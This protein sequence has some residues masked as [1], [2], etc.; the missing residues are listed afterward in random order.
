M[1]ARRHG[2]CDLDRVVTLDNILDGDDGVGT[3]GHDTTSGDRHRL[4][5]AEVARRGLAGGD[6]A[7]HR[8]RAG[9]VDATN[10]VPVHRGAPERRQ[11]DDC[12][13]GL[14]RDARERL[15]HGHVLGR[16]GMRAGEHER[17]RLLERE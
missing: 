12:A 2:R 3:A 9:K 8:Q 10:G 7:D 15:P 1:V 16:Q 11:V 13:H 17:L 5:G 6:L 4:A 14:R